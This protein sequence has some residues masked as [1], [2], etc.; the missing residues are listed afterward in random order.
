MELL[1]KISDKL[2]ELSELFKDKELISK[3]GI[4]IACNLSY[5]DKVNAFTMLVGLKENNI[6]NICQLTKS[7]D[8]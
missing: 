4:A 3:S 7:I 5:G 2:D 1:Q 6:F 8:L